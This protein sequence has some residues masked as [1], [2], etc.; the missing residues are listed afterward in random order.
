M[1]FQKCAGIPME[2]RDE[3]DRAREH[4]GFHKPGSPED[5][6]GSPVS[7]RQHRGIGSQ[8]LLSCPRHVQ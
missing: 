7:I 1:G 8:K 5:D 4:F 2:F 3:S 6:R